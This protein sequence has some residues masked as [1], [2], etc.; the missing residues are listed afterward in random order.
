MSKGTK[1]RFIG[2]TIYCILAIFITIITNSKVV[3]FVL[4]A[5]AGAALL[6]GMSL[7]YVE[8]KEKKNENT[9]D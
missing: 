5:L 4:G 8:S 9:K 1:A 3:V 2:I 7:E 6:G